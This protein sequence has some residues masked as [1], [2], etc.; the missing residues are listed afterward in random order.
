MRSISKGTF[1]IGSIQ[2]LLSRDEE[3]L[4]MS[5]HKSINELEPSFSQ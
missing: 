3:R 1:N 4:I 2:L 5:L